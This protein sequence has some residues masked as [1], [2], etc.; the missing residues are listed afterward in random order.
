MNIRETISKELAED[1]QNLL[2]E[3]AEKVEKNN[4]LKVLSTLGDIL[5]GNDLSEKAKMNIAKTGSYATLALGAIGVTL[6][7]ADAALTGMEPYS[8]EQS[9]EAQSA[10]I[11][12]GGL[13]LATGVA[14]KS[15]ADNIRK[16]LVSDA[17]LPPT[18][19]NILLRED[20]NE[21][22]SDPQNVAKVVE[23]LPK[24]NLQEIKQLAWICANKERIQKNQAPVNHEYDPPKEGEIRLDKRS[25]IRSP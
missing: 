2:L 25:I 22:L 7:F 5:S 23:S 1:V 19:K 8:A 16:D 13:A 3:Y 9:Y 6:G 14:L 20:I 21:V 10:I 12:I 24:D 11:G 18:V 17:R 4:R 15:L